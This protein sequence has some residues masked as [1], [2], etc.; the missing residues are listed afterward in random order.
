MSYICPAP[1][2]AC[3]LRV[4]QEDACGRVV[5]PLTPNSRLIL[6][7]FAMVEATPNVVDGNEIAP[8]TACGAYSYYVKTQ[9]RVTS[10]TLSLTVNRMHLPLLSMML[11]AQLLEDPD[12]AGDFIGFD[13]PDDLTRTA[14]DPKM[15]EL[16]STDA[17]QTGC[18]A[19]SNLPYFLHTFKLTRN[20]AQSEAMAFNDTDPTSVTL[21]GEAFK[22]PNWFPSYPATTFPS[23]VPGGGDPTGTPTGAAPPVLPAGATADPWT[24]A[25]Q[26]IL[27]TGG[28]Y[29]G[30]AW[31]TIPDI[32][33]YSCS[34]FPEGS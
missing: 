24:L 18:S 21:T 33:G 5:D 14:P 16:W 9:R 30:R 29:T 13:S 11:D 26:T 7:D 28:P 2:L 8:R 23:W 3:M 31:P 1:I 17:D 32:T 20:W 22:N 10:W 27:Q 12:N 19:E 6:A 34:F 25:D 4:T 15:L